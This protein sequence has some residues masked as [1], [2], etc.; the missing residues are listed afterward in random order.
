MSRLLDDHDEAV[1]A[2]AFRLAEVV[3]VFLARNNTK[4][5]LLAADLDRAVVLELLEA[6]DRMTEART[7]RI[8]AARADASGEQ[9]D[10]PMST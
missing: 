8:R 5:A 1:Y 7:A 3:R 9:S 6:N 4:S 10:E 2:E